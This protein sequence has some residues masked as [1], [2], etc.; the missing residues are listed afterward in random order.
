MCIIYRV[1]YAILFVSTNAA[2]SCQAYVTAPFVVIL[3]CTNS[4]F[5]A[6]YQK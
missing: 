4:W 5:K 3:I 6:R 1:L 2:D